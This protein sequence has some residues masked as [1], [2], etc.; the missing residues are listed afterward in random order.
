MG[1]DVKELFVGLQ[2]FVE[3]MQEIRSK[4]VDVD[5]YLSSEDGKA[6]LSK[7]SGELLVSG[8]TETAKIVAELD[9]TV[10]ALLVVW[11]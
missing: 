5:S 4:I 10:K 6:Q 11:K 3:A 7:L 9:K 1:I 8:A 2:K